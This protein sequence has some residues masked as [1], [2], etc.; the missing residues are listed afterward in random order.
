MARVHTIRIE[1]LTAEAFAPFGKLI[2]VDGRA[3]DYVAASGTQGWLVGFESGRPLVSLLRTPFQDLRFRTMERHFHV[4][5]A[6]IPLGG[7]HAAVAV[8]PP[9]ED[10]GIPPL[11][12]IRA[13]LLDGSKG[14]VL[15]RGTWH[16]LDRFPLRAPDARFVMI[17][18]HETQDDLTAAY[19]AGRPAALTQEI[20]LERA[21][22]VTIELVV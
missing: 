9:S 13:F 1:P 8:A 10:A 7:E 17:T 12:A 14:Y 18:D 19:R 21:L 4:S 5:Q 6:F 16:S 15:H 11:D 3:P 20:D 22:G 2:D